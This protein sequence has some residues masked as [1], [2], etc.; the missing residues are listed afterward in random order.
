MKNYLL[1][2]LA[3]GGMSALY[4]QPVVPDGSFESWNAHNAVFMPGVWLADTADVEADYIQRTAT[5]SEGDY[6]IRIGTDPSRLPASGVSAEVYGTLSEDP[7]TLDFD[8]IVQNNTS[9]MVNGLVVTVYFYDSTDS[10][11]ANNKWYSPSNANNSSFVS[12]SLELGSYN[13]ASYLI[14]IKYLNANGTANEYGILDNL[15]FTEKKPDPSSVEGIENMKITLYPNPATEEFKLASDNG[16]TP[17]EVAMIGMDG[18]SQKLQSNADG[19]FSISTFENGVYII[20]WIDPKN[21]VIQR[22]RIV[23][24]H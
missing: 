23:I 2:I 20:Q 24:R 19:V 16:Y 8:Y 4:A 17:N 5:S 9:S 12:A 22:K 15:H 3:V 7:G 6:A 11:L 21:Q 14:E 18:K 13:A 1:A 10:Y